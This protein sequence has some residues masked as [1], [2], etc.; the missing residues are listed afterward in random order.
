MFQPE[1]EERCLRG[2]VCLPSPSFRLS[3]PAEFCVAVAVIVSPVFLASLVSFIFV[4]VCF[5]HRLKLTGPALWFRAG[6]G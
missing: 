5:G 2:A 3:A 1:N 4:V 6:P